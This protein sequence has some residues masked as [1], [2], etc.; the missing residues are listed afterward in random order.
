MIRRLIEMADA[1]GGRAASYKTRPQTLPLYF[2]AGPRAYKLGEEAYVS[3]PDFSLKDSHRADLRHGMAHG[4]CEGLSL[5][6]IPTA[7][8]PTVPGELWVISDGWLRNQNAREKGFLLGAFDDRYIHSQPVAVVRREGVI[9]AFATLICPDMLH[10]EASVDL[11]RYRSDVPS[12]TVD[13]LFGEVILHFQAQGYQRFGL[14][15]APMS[16]MVEYQL[17]PRWHRFGRMVFRHGACFCNFKGLRSFK[18]KSE[19]V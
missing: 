2:D 11:M 18:D 19:P 5:E 4:E 17:T 13:F 12:G 1:H 8:A 10:T 14:G 9:V 16:G 6:I 15:M 7:D 3:P